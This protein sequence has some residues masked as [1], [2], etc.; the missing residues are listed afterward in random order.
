MLM[1]EIAQKIHEHLKRLEGEGSVSSL[2]N[3]QAY[4]SGPRVFIR[5][6]SYWPETSLTKA[7]A[8]QYLE[9]LDAGNK[10]DVHK[11]MRETAKGGN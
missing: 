11:W 5:I 9:W 1:R 10:G 3:P 6:K 8:A 7:R 2:Y 4:P